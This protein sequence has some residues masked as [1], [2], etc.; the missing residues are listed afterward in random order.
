VWNIGTKNKAKV[1]RKMAE[2]RLKQMDEEEK[3][4]KEERKA[5]KAQL[6]QG[7]TQEE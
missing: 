4:L 2:A 1:E 7:A 5:L 3:K 6:G